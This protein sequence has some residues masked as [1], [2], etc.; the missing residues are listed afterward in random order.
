V[1]GVM[2]IELGRG[3]MIVE[4]LSI[5]LFLPGAACKPYQKALA[6]SGF[7]SSSSGLAIQT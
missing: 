7:G 1:L 4:S 2:E 6:V 5:S 3:A